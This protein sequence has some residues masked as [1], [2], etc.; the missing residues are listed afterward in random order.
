MSTEEAHREAVRRLPG[1]SLLIALT[2]VLI[3][4]C[5]GVAAWL[6]YD[7]A[8]IASGQLWRI[9]TCHL[10]HWSVDHLVWDVAALLVLGALCET[11][12]RRG[13]LRCVA[14]AAVLIPA[15][16]GWLM[17]DLPFYRGLSGIDSALFVWLATTLLRECLI[18]RRPDWAAV[19]I[20]VLCAF[21]AKTGFEFVT[22]QTL[23]VDS[24]AATMI[25]IPLAHVVGG[26]V[27]ILCGLHRSPSPRRLDKCESRAAGFNS[28]EGT[29]G[30]SP[31]LRRCAA[32]IRR[33][34]PQPARYRADSS[35]RH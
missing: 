11:S 3:Q 6:E 20:T 32:G 2:A 16:I 31:G 25:P 18:A 8:A 26:L 29:T 10:T 14:A 9:V 21:V 7:R 34:F 5:P 23:F 1:A 15:S 17:P 30:R 13:M 27:A 12:D 4:F 19:V 22:G 24:T 35:G 28:R 33:S